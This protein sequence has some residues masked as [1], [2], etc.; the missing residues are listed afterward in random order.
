MSRT[1]EFF[2]NGQQKVL[3]NFISCL[4]MLKKNFERLAKQHITTSW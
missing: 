3:N 1:E 4:T 2:Q